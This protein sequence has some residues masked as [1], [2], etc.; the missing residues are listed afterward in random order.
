MFKS[1]FLLSF[2]VFAVSCG[3][4]DSIKVE[5]EAQRLGDGTNITQTLILP[6][7]DKVLA[8]YDDSTKTL[9]PLVGG[10]LRS[11]MNVAASMGAGK[12]RVSIVQRMPEAQD[13]PDELSSLKIKRIFFIVDKKEV[14]KE[15]KEKKTAK[16]K[17]YFS[18]LN[19]FSKRDEEEEKE[20]NVNF[21]FLEGLALQMSVHNVKFENDTW[22]PTV[23]TASLT[24]DEKQILADS[25]NVK[26][27]KL[28]ESSFNDYRNESFLLLSYAK[29]VEQKGQ[30]VEKKKSKTHGST[31][32][33]STENPAETRKYFMAKDSELRPLI[34]QTTVLNKT[35]LIEVNNDVVDES[36]FM[37]LMNSDTQKL[38]N[39][40]KNMKICK[41]NCLDFE[42]MDLNLL[43]LIKQGNALRIDALIDPGKNPPTFQLKGYIEFEVKL[44]SAI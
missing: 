2:I 21:N 27:Y 35:L 31:F 24:K 38:A 30:K 39:I 7:S 1:L 5:T 40:N 19:P 26:N 34:K 18:N 20:E 32:I 10:I 41:S 13:I 36:L 11:V 25:K 3:K 16:I 9:S 29:M 23:E 4:K 22:E 6:L 33:V 42:L 15:E 44:K 43:P 28:N 17:E 37:G 14:T 8:S 12:T